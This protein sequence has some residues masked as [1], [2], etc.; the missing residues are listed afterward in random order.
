[1][2]AQEDKTEIPNPWTFQ[3][4]SVA[5]NFNNH[6]T[7]QLP[8]YDMAT[9]LVA[10][11]V[12][13]YIPQKGVLYDFGASTGNITDAVRWVLKERTVTAIS[14]DNSE[15]MLERW[16]GYG[17]KVLADLGEF[18]AQPYD[19]G[20]CFLT[21]MFL[22][23]LK[24]VETLNRLLTNLNKGGVFILFEKTVCATGYL[25]VSMLRLTMEQKYRQ[26]VKLDAILSKELSL[27]GVQRPLTEDPIVNK[28]FKVTQIFQFGDFKGWAIEKV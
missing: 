2:N 5:E 17:N 3:D 25:G 11:L 27:I 28:G 18:T 8:W 21:L 15:E 14:V 1:M 22:S 9:Q 12:K 26:G 13:H 16:K 20:I 4:A 10:H 7:S 6:V 19:V 23:P 24:Q